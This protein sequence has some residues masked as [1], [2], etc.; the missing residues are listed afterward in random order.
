M[1]FVCD[2]CHAQYM[3]SDEKV[4]PAGVRVRCKKCGHIITVKRVAESAPTPAAPERDQTE[5]MSN[6]LANLEGDASSAPTDSGALTDAAAAASPQPS[7]P[8]SASEL[9]DEIGQAFDSVLGGR[10]SSSIPVPAAEGTVTDP[11]LTMPMAAAGAPAGGLV[12]SG[13]EDPDRLATR[14][15]DL[16]QYA[17]LSRAGASD[18]V[19][20]ASRGNGATEAAT[21][22]T[23]WYVA[24]NDRQLG[25]FDI[26]AVREHWDKGELTPDSLVWRAGFG[27]WKPLSTVGELANLVAPVPRAPP[28]GATAAGAQLPWQVGKDNGAAAGPAAAAAS[29]D[30]KAEPE[31]KPSAA[32][33]LASLVEEEI[34]AL[35]KPTP[36][37]GPEPLGVGEE[38]PA[39]KGLLDLPEAASEMTA[40]GRPPAELTPSA[41]RRAPETIESGP[42]AAGSPYAAEEVSRPRPRARATTEASAPWRRDRSSRALILAIFGGFLAAGGLVAL[43]LVLVLRSPS[44]PAETVEMPPPPAG[45]AR[46]PT[47]PAPAASP[48]APN[49]PGPS[50]AP[51]VS[52]PAAP[53]AA[54][55]AAPAAAARSAEPKVATTKKAP[56]EAS[57]APSPKPA[58]EPRALAAKKAARDD[59]PDPPRKSKVD[60]A[61]EE[62]FGRREEEP[63]RPAA[64]PKRSVFVPPAVGTPSKESLSQADIMQVVL[65]QKPAIA[66][67]VKQYQEKNPGEH[68]TIVMKWTIRND[69]RTTGVRCDT[70]D[71]AGSVLDKCLAGAI[72]TW[73]FPAYSGAPQTIPF[74]FKF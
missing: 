14:V 62:L 47:V 52:A 27:D 73:Q 43:T 69:G 23:D 16:A 51:E 71:F 55:P 54:D 21:K 19:S 66:T 61:F 17:N 60:D 18:L 40:P 1:R 34:K 25:P 46:Q 72:K 59:E 41:R 29:A 31:W 15:M 42:M 50:R 38:R 68:G 6:P 8:F 57:A 64:K 48:P 24:I 32:S 36:K 13:A 12:V 53:A 63:E 56:R 5:V 20:A 30:A 37:R 26:D 44:R 11:N 65:S 58:A 10:G 39:K 22:T 4:G 2:S 49:E 74:P 3:I 67:C 28:A 70:D 7:A 9:D 35:T 33:A 45:M